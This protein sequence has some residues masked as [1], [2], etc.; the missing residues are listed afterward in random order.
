LPTAGSSN[1]LGLSSGCVRITS[2]TNRRQRIFAVTQIG[3]SFVLLVGASVLITTLIELQR[4]QTGMDTHHVLAIDVPAMSYGKTPQ[5]VVDF[6]KESMRRIDALPGVNKTAF[7][8]VVPWRDAGQGP[9]LQFSGDGHVHTPG[10]EDPPIGVPF[11]LD[12]LLRWVFLSFPVA[13]LTILMAPVGSPSLSSVKLLQS[14]C[15]PMGMPS[16]AMSIG[17]ILCCN[18]FPGPNPKRRVFSPH[19]ASSVLPPT[20]TT[21]TLF[22]S[23]S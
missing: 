5:Q 16:I 4:A 20:L 18:S 8:N 19:T 21:N 3:A 22:P 10:V 13:I 12:F 2:S 11:L 23:P 7:G 1:G 14:A 15:S 6:Y 17:R 9:G